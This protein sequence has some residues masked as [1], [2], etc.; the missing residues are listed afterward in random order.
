[1]SA[2]PGWDHHQRPAPNPGRPSFDQSGE[3]VGYNLNDLPRYE[4]PPPPQ[5]QRYR[6]ARLSQADK[7]IRISMTG[8][9]TS[10]FLVTTPIAVVGVVISAIALRRSQPGDKDHATAMAGVILGILALLIALLV[11][12]RISAV[13]P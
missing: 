5:L 4:Q 12:L 8:L 2:S 3:P 13:H 10:L 7:G 9:L 1:M 6:V 11:F